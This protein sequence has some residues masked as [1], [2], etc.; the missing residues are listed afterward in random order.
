MARTGKPVTMNRL[1]FEGM[2]LVAAKE[3]V[4]AHQAECSCHPVSH[5]CCSRW[6]DVRAVIYDGPTKIPTSASDASDLDRRP[7]HIDTLC[8]VR[9]EARA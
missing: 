8:K 2:D 6:S 4:A 7:W 3:Q 9:P 5:A 1:G